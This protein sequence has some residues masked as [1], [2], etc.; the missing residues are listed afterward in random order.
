VGLLLENVPSKTTVWQLKARL[1]EF[2]GVP[3]IAATMAGTPQ[4]KPAL[5]S[6]PNKKAEKKKKKFSAHNRT[7]T[8]CST[9]EC[10]VEARCTLVS[11]QKLQKVSFLVFVCLFVC[12]FFFSFFFFYFFIL[13]FFF[14]YH[15]QSSGISGS[16]KVKPG[17]TLPAMTRNHT[18]LS[19]AKKFFSSKKKSNPCAELSFATG[20]GLRQALLNVEAEFEL[21]AVDSQ[22][23]LLGTEAVAWDL[24]W[25]LFDESGLQFAG[26]KIA[27][28]HIKAT[29][30]CRARYTPTRPGN[31]L[32]AIKTTVNGQAESISGSPFSVE[33]IDVDNRAEI[34]IP[35]K[36]LEESWSLEMS[37]VLVGFSREPEAHRRIF[38]EIGISQVLKMA[39]Y[40]DERIAENLGTCLENLLMID[41]NKVR[42]VSECAVELVRTISDVC[43]RVSKP[44]LLR[45]MGKVLALLVEQEALR[46]EVVQALGIQ[47]VQFL[48][49][50][51]DASCSLSAVRALVHISHDES[52]RDILLGAG[53]VPGLWSLLAR[54]TDDVFLQRQVMRALA[55]LSDSIDRFEADSKVWFVSLFFVVFVPKKKISSL[56]IVLLSE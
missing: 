49:Q 19:M 30:G 51:N 45:F 56:L 43:S 17:S 46:A 12:F 48:L 9:W 5:V 55:N 39:R 10:A 6:L 53:L 20:R 29:R 13:F 16:L 22:G 21:Y 52:Q 34:S 18:G 7:L 41:Q 50:Q 37:I 35:K 14:F 2:L 8:V 25:E 11:S 33:V 40:R 15:L 44:E 47:P 26:I 31:Y 42:I 54:S 1:M 3:P 38:E 36:I 27:L 32:L 4:G 28:E 23:L 24:T